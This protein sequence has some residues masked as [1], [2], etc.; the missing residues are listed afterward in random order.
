L[1]VVQQQDQSEA[2]D[3]LKSLRQ[4]EA[5]LREISAATTRIQSHD[6][7][8]KVLELKKIFEEKNETFFRLRQEQQSVN[9][10][11]RTQQHLRRQ[12]EHMEKLQQ[13]LEA[14][15]NFEAEL[16]KER[17]TLRAQMAELDNQI[18]SLRIKEVDAIN[19]EHGEKVCLTLLSDS[20]STGYA[21]LLSSMLSGSRLRSQEEVAVAIAETFPPAALIDITV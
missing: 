16:L 4:M 11:L 2:V 15:Q 18:Y 12:I 8:S 9:E 3:A 17:E 20:S 19:K 5:D 7:Q 21:A 14:A 1:A 13:D 10:S 6:L